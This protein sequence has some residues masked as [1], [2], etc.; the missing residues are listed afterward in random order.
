MSLKNLFGKKSLSVSKDQSLEDLVRDIE[1]VDYLT[2]HKKEKDRFVPNIDWS[3]PSNFSKHGSAEKYYVD[4]ISNIYRTYPYD[5]SL[6]EKKAWHNNS[7]DL[8]NYI[9]DNIYPRNNGYVNIGVNY[10]TTMAM[11]SGYYSSSIEEY[12]YFNGSLNRDPAPTK[13]KDL[14]NK[15]NKLDIDNIAF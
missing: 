7:S 12:I 11:S 9:F 2:E 5:G 10:G 4:A 8:S 15:S 13:L 14:F 3:D 1:S 6:K